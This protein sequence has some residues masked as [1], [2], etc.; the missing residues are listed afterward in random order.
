MY[1]IVMTSWGG[2]RRDFATGLTEK[3]AIETCEAYCWEYQ[4]NGEGY[5]WEL[6]IEEE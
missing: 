6:E 5:I 3:D 2:T 1:K 4:V